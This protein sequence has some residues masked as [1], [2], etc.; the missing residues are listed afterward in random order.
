MDENSITKLE[1]LAKTVDATALAALLSE[2]QQIINEL[3]RLG[4]EALKSTSG[5]PLPSSASESC[6]EP[7]MMAHS[8]A[9]SEIGVTTATVSTWIKTG[10]IRGAKVISSRK[11]LGPVSEVER[12]KRKVQP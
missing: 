7:P 1:S 11:K 10:R 12:M 9:A 5:P 3:A 8:D 2:N 6:N 4:L